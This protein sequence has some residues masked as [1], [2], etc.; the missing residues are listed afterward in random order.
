MY[1]T[2]LTYRCDTLATAKGHHE[3]LDDTFEK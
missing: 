1:K 2:H 3:K